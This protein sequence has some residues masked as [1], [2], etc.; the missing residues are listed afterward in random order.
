MN[1][2]ISNRHG[3]TS[4]S[5][6]SAILEQ[7]G[8]LG[9]KVLDTAMSYGDSEA[10]LGAILKPGHDFKIITKL[11]PIRESHLSA[12]GVETVVSQHISA[13]LGRL[14]QKSIY[15]LLIHHADDLLSSSGRALFDVVLAT[16][17]AGGVQRI[18]VSVYTPQQLES[19]LRLYP[20]EIVQ[21]PLSVFDQR[22]LLGG[23]L[24]MLKRNGI[25]VH[26]R[27]VFLQGLLLM[28]PRTV[29][30]YFDDLRNNL[31][32]FH[33]ACRRH[34]MTPVEAALAFTCGTKEVDIVVCGV[35]TLQQFCELVAGVDRR[36]DTRVLG[37]FAVQ[38]ERWLNPSLWPKF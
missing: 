26:V 8:S 37:E 2:G 29:P 23:H 9:V 6:V 25:E 7:A 32:K 34:G 4:C 19:I 15:G 5:D 20:V 3:Q 16:R 17:E 12:H 31:A 14:Q 13:S 18:G 24:A 22:F 36:V 30:D 27:S 1:Y 11:A 35:N 10:I 21:L 28:D 38:D 33:E